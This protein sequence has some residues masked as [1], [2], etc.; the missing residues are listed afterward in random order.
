MK[1]FAIGYTIFCLGFPTVRETCV[2]NN[3]NEE[4][5]S[6]LYHIHAVLDLCDSARGCCSHHD[7][8]AYCDKKVRRYMCNDGQYS[9]ECRCK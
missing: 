1:C 8:V 9:P 4:L 2:R 7:G 6:D 5:S 3:L